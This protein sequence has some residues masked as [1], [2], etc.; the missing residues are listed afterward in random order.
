MKI[1]CMVKKKTFV[2]D[3]NACAF[4][5]SSCFVSYVLKYNVKSGISKMFSLNSWYTTTLLKSRF[6]N[7]P[8]SEKNKSLIIL[9]SSCVALD[10]K[11]SSQSLSLIIPE[12]GIIRSPLKDSSLWF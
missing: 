6:R 1:I 4:H 12:L 7:N 8:C 9:L 3:E 2:K 11:L 10:H 5:V